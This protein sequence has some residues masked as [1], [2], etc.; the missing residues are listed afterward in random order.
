MNGVAALKTVEA[1]N[2]GLN[3]VSEVIQTLDS[4]SSSEEE[5]EK[6]SGS[7]SDSNGDEVWNF[8]PEESAISLAAFAD[9]SSDNDEIDFV[10]ETILKIRQL[11]S[12]KMKIY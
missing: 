9:E 7:R 6:P 2:S 3:T 1:G 12:F 8:S 5:K 11:F 10:D 4:S